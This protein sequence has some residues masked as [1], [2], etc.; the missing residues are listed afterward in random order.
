MDKIERSLK[1]EEYLRDAPIR[2]MN[3]ALA[4]HGW[5]QDG[6][7]KASKQVTTPREYSMDFPRSD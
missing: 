5:R 1:L 2:A 7:G 3:A 6:T 4:R